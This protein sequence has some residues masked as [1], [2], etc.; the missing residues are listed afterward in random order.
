METAKFYS[1]AVHQDQDNCDSFTL[2]SCSHDDYLIMENDKVF[3]MNYA[4]LITEANI[5][6]FISRFPVL[7]F[8]KK[9]VIDSLN[10]LSLV[11]MKEFASSSSKFLNINSFS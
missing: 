2:G 8:A 1:F 9:P 5:N 10:A 3:L 6:A 7:L 4:K 11:S